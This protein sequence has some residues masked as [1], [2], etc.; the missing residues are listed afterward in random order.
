MTANMKSKVQSL[1]SNQLA[2]WELW[3][4]TLMQNR[5]EA[6]AED[7]AWG[8]VVNRMDCQ[9]KGMPDLHPDVESAVWSV[10]F[11]IHADL[12]HGKDRPGKVSPSWTEYPDRC[13]CFEEAMQQMKLNGEWAKLHSHPKKA[14]FVLV[15]PEEQHWENRL[16]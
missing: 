5:T 6:Q 12:P 3:K 15:D 11:K 10:A 14:E 16:E 1:T 7:D 9:R 2:F 4:R 13:N 8:L